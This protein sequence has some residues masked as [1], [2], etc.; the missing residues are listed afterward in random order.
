MRNRLREIILKSDIL[1]D[2]CGE[3][4][5]SYCAEALADAILDEGVILPPCKVGDIVYVLGKFT[6]QIIESKVMTISMSEDDV[7]LHLDN[8][9]YVTESQQI[10]KTAFLTRKEARKALKQMEKEW[11]L[12]NDR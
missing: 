11:R 8:G 2:S 6:G 1:C 12:S 4:T 3:N 10:G 9:T 5:S 7:F